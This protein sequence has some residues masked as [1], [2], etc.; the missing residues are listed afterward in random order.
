MLTELRMI[1]TL[2]FH[3]L[4]NRQPVTAF[5]PADG[6][7]AQPV[8]VWAELDVRGCAFSDF[9]NDELDMAGI[10]APDDTETR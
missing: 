1:I 5:P 3:R 2:W 10:A 8:S 6:V 9:V 7:N 4:V